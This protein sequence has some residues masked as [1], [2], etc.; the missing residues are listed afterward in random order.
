MND[1]TPKRVGVLGA[2]QLALMLADDDRAGAIAGVEPDERGGGGRPRQQEK[3][4]DTGQHYIPHGR[5]HAAT[6]GENLSKKCGRAWGPDDFAVN[7]DE[8]LVKE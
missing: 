3:R 7:R 2:G 8:S 4:R 5:P 6:V 1:V